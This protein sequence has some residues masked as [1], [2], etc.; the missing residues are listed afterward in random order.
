MESAKSNITFVLFSFNEEKRIEYAVRNLI[1]YG[2]VLILDDGSTDR[3]KEIAESLGARLVRRP[4]NPLYYTETQ[5][6]LDF[7]KSLINTQWIY[8]SYF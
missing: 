1:K 7:A 6:M 3:T 4:A 2:E 5:A 8:W